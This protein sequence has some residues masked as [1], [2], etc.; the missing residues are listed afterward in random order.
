M[1]SPDEVP[2]NGKVVLPAK[3]FPA[4]VIPPARDPTHF[5]GAFAPTERVL[6]T[7]RNCL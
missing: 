7:F 2:V 6:S 3:D 5:E 4:K 1:V